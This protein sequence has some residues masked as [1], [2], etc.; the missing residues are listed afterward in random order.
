MKRKRLPVRQ[1]IKKEIIP[2]INSVK[3]GFILDDEV[4]NM[5]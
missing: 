1:K 4:I 5:V 2:K 3:T